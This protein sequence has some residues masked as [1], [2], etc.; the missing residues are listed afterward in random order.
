VLAVML[1]MTLGFNKVSLIASVLYLLAGAS[2]FL[3]KK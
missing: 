3:L 1:A 2:F